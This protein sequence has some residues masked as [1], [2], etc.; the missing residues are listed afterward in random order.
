MIEWARITGPQFEELPKDIAIL[1]VGNIE[2]HGDHLPL[3]ADLM[4]PE[5]ISREVAKRLGNAVLLPP[6][7]YGSSKAMREFP[8]TIDIDSNAFREYVKS[9]MKE[10]IRNGFKLLVIINGH[11][12]NTLPLQ[13]AAREA[14]YEVGGSIL[15]INWWSDVAKDKRKELFPESS[16]GHGGADETSAIMFIAPECVDL[17]KAKSNPIPYPRMRFYSRDYEVK[18]LFP[19]AV[20]GDPLKSSREK[21]REF[22][23]SVVN[24]VIETIKKAEELIKHS[25]T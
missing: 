2:R 14:T 25:T 17:S 22:L 11:G 20:T 10:V 3:G 16:W 24:E 12:G 8:G 7:P 9:V 1:P 5:W 21:G 19:N 15:I 4:A 18:V 23:E 13:S 6:I